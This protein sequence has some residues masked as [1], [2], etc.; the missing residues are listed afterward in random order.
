M[1]TAS[2]NSDREDVMQKQVHR[3]MIWIA[4]FLILGIPTIASAF[5]ET[6]PSDPSQREMSNTLTDVQ[7]AQVK[8]ILSKYDAS[9]LTAA[10]AKAIFEAFRKAG[11]RG[12]SGLMEAIRVSG[13]DPEKLRALA[14]PPER[15]PDGRRLPD[16]P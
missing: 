15:P 2:T 1:N 3:I 9:S 4:A 13:F 8:S 5:N 10:D 12:G 7:K 6:R 11:L 16:A 14:P